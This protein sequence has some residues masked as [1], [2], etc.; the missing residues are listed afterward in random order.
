MIDNEQI[1]TVLIVKDG[2]QI[3]R[4][5]IN[6][7]LI[8][9]CAAWCLVM[10]LVT[11]T[12]TLSGL[13][14]PVFQRYSSVLADG[15]VQPS[16][17]SEFV[18]YALE[19]PQVTKVI[20]EVAEEAP[21]DQLD[22]PAAV[23]V[24]SDAEPVNALAGDIRTVD[25]MEDYGLSLTDVSVSRANIS[26]YAT[27]VHYQLKNITDDGK[28]S[29]FITVIPEYVFGERTTYSSFPEAN[30]TED[31]DIDDFQNGDTF[32]IRWFKEVNCEIQASMGQLNR[33]WFYVHTPEGKLILRDSFDMAETVQEDQFVPRDES[34]AAMVDRIRR[35]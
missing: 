9:R 17:H 25:L 20:A 10:A 23:A 34:L 15:M 28:I 6:L 30:F 26:G 3:H 16:T 21:V 29:G 5:A 22:A 7:Q 35:F 32:Q 2:S 8:R 19:K 12:I 31:G 4:F 33:V 1:L 27:K 18:A 13:I 24:S 14:S 11:G